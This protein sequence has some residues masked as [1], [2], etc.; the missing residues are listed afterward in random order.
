MF[1]P[2]CALGVVE[3]YEVLQRV[4][5]SPPSFSRQTQTTPC[6]G[7]PRLPRILYYARARVWGLGRASKKNAS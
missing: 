3:L 6:K 5:V 4:S 2:T 7:K 1:Y